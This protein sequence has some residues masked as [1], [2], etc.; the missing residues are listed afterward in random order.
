M[1][2]SC[3]ICSSNP[4]FSIIGKPRKDEYEP[5]QTAAYSKESFEKL[6]VNQQR[7]IQ[8]RGPSR[9][10]PGGGTVMFEGEP[11]ADGI[12]LLPSIPRLF[13]RAE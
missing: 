10:S 3:A 1:F 5:E 8:G 13:V 11:L 2:P 6:A 7:M 9:K 4:S 12:N